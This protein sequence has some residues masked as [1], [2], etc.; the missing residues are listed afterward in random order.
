MKAHLYGYKNA[1]EIIAPILLLATFFVDMLH[2][3]FSSVNK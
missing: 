2:N 1:L 3:E